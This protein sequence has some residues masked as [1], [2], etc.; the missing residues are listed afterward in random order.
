MVATEGPAV[1]KL[2]VEE[3]MFINRMTIEALVNA[4]C[5]A[6]LKVYNNPRIKH[7]GRLV[8]TTP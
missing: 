6:K 8:N 2:P 1:A 4:T 7:L 5:D 3:A